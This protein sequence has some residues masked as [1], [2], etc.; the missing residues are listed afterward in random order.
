MAK[1]S[2]VCLTAIL[3]KVLSGAGGA[4]AKRAKSGAR[5]L[6]EIRFN[7]TT[8]I[9]Q[10]DFTNQETAQKYSLLSQKAALPTCCQVVTLT[11]CI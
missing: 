4:K 6:Q 5:A 10:L 9:G 7:F 8:W 2:V 3:S 1:Y 11:S